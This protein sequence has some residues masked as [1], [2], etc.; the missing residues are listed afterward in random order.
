MVLEKH[1]GVLL[2]APERI[3]M[4]EQTFMRPEQYAIVVARVQSN[5][6]ADIVKSKLAPKM[7]AMIEGG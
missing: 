1:P 4:Q 2:P 6:E 7:M 3:R 5:I